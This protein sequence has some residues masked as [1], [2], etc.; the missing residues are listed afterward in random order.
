MSYYD[1]GCDKQYIQADQPIL[2]SS[3][4]EHRRLA[5]AEVGQALMDWAAF[6][7]SPGRFSADYWMGYNEA[8][9]RIRDLELVLRKAVADP[10]TPEYWAPQAKAILATSETHEIQAQEG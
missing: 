4:K 10:I 5:T 6:K 9:A 1:C 2:R 8:Q 7:P 3:C